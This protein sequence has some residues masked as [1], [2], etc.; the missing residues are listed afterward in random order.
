MVQT[1]DRTYGAV[2]QET[3]KCV[4]C[5]K[6]RQEECVYSRKIIF[7]RLSF[8]PSFWDPPHIPDQDSRML[9]PIPADSR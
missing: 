5:Y 8:H 6:Y 9:D 2:Q 1:L 3:V 4:Y 7:V